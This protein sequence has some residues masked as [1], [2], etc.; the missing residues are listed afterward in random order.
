[1][2]KNEVQEGD[3]PLG[4]DPLSVASGKW[5]HAHPLHF[6]MLI[7]SCWGWSVVGAYILAQA[8]SIYPTLYPFDRTGPERMKHLVTG[9]GCSVLLQGLLSF[10]ADVFAPY[11]LQAGWD[12][13]DNCFSYADIFMALINTGLGAVYM[14]SCKV[15]DDRNPALTAMAVIFVTSC[16]VFFP[17]SVIQFRNENFLAWVWCHFLWHIIPQLSACGAIYILS[18]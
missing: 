16:A 14:S 5:L 3:D 6:V 9:Y 11:Y 4:R 17:C 13:R 7:V 8:N 15:S 12:R 1:M 10:L 2:E 18:T